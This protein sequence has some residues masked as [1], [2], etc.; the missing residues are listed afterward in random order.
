MIT[1]FG[2]AVGLE[3]DRIVVGAPDDADVDYTGAAYL[4]EEGFGGWKETAKFYGSG[5][6]AGDSFGSVIDLA[7]SEA[8]IGAPHLWTDP[9]P[10]PGYTFHFDL[11]AADPSV[12]ADATSV[13]LSQGGV[14]SLQLG[15]CQ[16]HAGD[17]YVLAGSATGTSPGFLLAGKAVPLNADPYFLFS[18]KHRNAPPLGG[19][20]GVLDASGKANAAFALPPGT[21]PGLA[22]LVLHHAYCVLDAATLQVEAVSDAVPVALVP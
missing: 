21:D 10:T 12:L 20:T 4:F 1:R 3:G 14:Q 11:D 7:G 19:S 15:A 6:V 8:L 22:G 16:D 9:D 13:S 18:L 5:L 17:L 2:W